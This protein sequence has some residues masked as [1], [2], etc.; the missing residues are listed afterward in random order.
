MKKIVDL[1]YEN[2]KLIRKVCYSFCTNN[3]DR[4]DFFQ[5]IVYKVLK[6]SNNFK[7][8]SKFSTWLYRVSL[9]TTITFDKKKVKQ[10][11]KSEL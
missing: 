9:N 2:Q 1:I 5:E 8:Q 4:E 11:S 6:S 3:E 7:N 10:C